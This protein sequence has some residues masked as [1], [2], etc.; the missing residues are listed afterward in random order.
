[1]VKIIYIE[2]NGNEYMFDV[3]NGLMVMEGVVCNMVFG[4]DV[5]C[6]GVCVCVICYV[7]VD[8]VWIEKIGVCEV[9]EDFMFDFV[10]GVEDNFCL[11][12]QIKVLDVFD[13]L[14][15][16]IFEYQG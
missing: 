14:I 12:C 1:M 13:G 9:M 5:D 6:G 16:C 2:Y 10:E 15:V 8:V 4:I 11:F 7:Y 3:D